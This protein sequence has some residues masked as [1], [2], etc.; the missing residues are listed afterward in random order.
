[1]KYFLF[2][3][4]LLF[5]SV[6][7]SPGL[8]MTFQENGPWIVWNSPEGIA[9]LQTSSAKENF[10]NLIRFYESQIRTTYC[11]VATSVI[12]LNALAI[13]APQS[14]FL[15][16]YRMF[17]QEEFFSEQV[18]AV[19][20]QADVAERGMSL[21]ELSRVLKTFP[22]QVNKYE[23]QSMSDDEMRHVLVAALKNPNQCVL[24]LYQRRELRQIGGGHWSPVAAYD[25]VS[26]SF[27]VLDVARFKYPPVWIDAAAFINSMKTYDITGTH[28]RG[29][30][31]IEKESGRSYNP[32]QNSMDIQES[33]S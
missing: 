1:M 32:V 23:A 17:T 10:W 8:K 11:S 16:Q 22:I 18:V 31:I 30:I 21:G 19:I 13:E 14:R 3:A 5:H 25:S 12:A 24:G 28:S 27:L 6:F 15:G 2:F 33:N 4:L 9:R 26:D 20:D 29:F 7:A